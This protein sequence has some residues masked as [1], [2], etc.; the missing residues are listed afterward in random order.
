MIQRQTTLSAN[1]LAFCRFLRTK[2]YAIGP[3]EEADALLGLELTN[4]FD[5]PLSFQLC[6]QSTLCRSPQQLKL[7]PDF[8]Q[9]YWKELD[10]AVDSKTKEKEEQSDEAQPAA[11]NTPTINAL[12]SWLYGNHQQ[13]TQETASYSAEGNSEPVDLLTYD[14]RDLRAVFKLVKKLLIKI[15]NRRSRRYQKSHRIAQL[16]LKSTIR[17]NLV[18]SSEIIKLKYKRK[19]K[20][21]INVVLLCDVSKSM[22]LYSRFFIQFMYAFQQQFP[23]VS[24]YVFSTT[25]HPVSKELT[26]RSLKT[27][28]KKMIAKVNQWG[29]GT[30]IGASLATFNEAY[31]HKQVNSKTLVII[32][33]DGWDS[34]EPA[35]VERNMRLLHRKALKVLWLNPLAGNPNWKPE[36]RAMAAALPYIDYLIPFHNIESLQAVVK[37]WKL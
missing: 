4:P 36:V 35:L 9:Q 11:D 24:T 3:A 19:K 1:L 13:D 37:N 27:S 7:F 18:R 32:L 17:H 16:D 20:D 14:E 12:K 6:L 30:Q 10:R 29:G 33:S 26:E 22:E 23:K 15:A 25:L 2:G 8:Y 5:D 21:Q 28:M 31:A 34:G